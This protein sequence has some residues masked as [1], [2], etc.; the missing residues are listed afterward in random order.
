MR[1]DYGIGVFGWLDRV[2]CCYGLFDLCVALAGKILSMSAA[3]TSI[4][5]QQREI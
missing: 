5:L 4:D 2:I 3:R 1:G